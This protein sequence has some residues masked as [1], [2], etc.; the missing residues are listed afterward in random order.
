M[1]LL[2]WSDVLSQ[3]E[4]SA[5]NWFIQLTQAH[6]MIIFFR[7]QFVLDLLSS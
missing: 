3:I 6:R 7:I 5:I 1:N 2:I 4:I